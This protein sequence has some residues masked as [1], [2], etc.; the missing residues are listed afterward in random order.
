M[1]SW[2]ILMMT[3]RVGQE[4]DRYQHQRPPAQCHRHPLEPAEAAGERGAGLR[5]GD[6]AAA[7]DAL[8]TGTAIRRVIPECGPVCAVATSPP[9][10]ASLGMG[11][12][13]LDLRVRMPARADPGLAS[14]L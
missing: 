10:S 11:P 7:P 14:R 9:V 3:I 5:D 13:P 2:M 1:A 12:G 6:H 4:V 8:R